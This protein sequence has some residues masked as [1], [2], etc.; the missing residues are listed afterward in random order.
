[1]DHA[2]TSGIAEPAWT[3]ATITAGHTQVSI[4]GVATTG[5]D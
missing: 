4:L 1:V 3:V 2:S 5:V